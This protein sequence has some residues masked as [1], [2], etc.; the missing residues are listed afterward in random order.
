MFN[1]L[2]V[3]DDLHTSKLLC[4]ILKH[5]GFQAYTAFDGLEVIDKMEQQHVDLVV[6]DLMMPRMDGFKLTEHLRQVWGD[7]PIMMVTA[8]QEPVDKKQ[9]FLAGTD[10]YMTKPIDE[11]EFI[12][13]IKALLRRAKIATEHQLIVGNTT[14][15]YDALTVSYQQKIVTLPQKEFYI[16]FKLLSYPGKIF[17]RLQLM[18]EFWG[19]D[20]ESD[21]HTL[22]V[23]MSRIRTKLMDNEDF[24]IITVR[25]LGYKAV[26]NDA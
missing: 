10:D 3:E 24:E 11:E 5:N 8:K 22:N 15:D 26:R 17:T 21:H 14:F 6:V 19:V 9:G 20:Y 13:R 4:A 7:L 25:G 18:E 1:I 16:L 2:V 12:L 23:H